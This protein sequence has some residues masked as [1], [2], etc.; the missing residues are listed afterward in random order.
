[1]NLEAAHGDTIRDAISE[2]LS[3]LQC[4][5]DHI[6]STR[7]Y[8]RLLAAAATASFIGAL[9]RVGLSRASLTVGKD[10]DIVTI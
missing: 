6:Y 10:A 5:K 3:L 1:M 4:L 9:H 2:F 8:A 7:H